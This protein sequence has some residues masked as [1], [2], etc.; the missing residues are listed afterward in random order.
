MKH[1]KECQDEPTQIRGEEKT[2][3]QRCRTLDELALVVLIFESRQ[4]STAC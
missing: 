4:I 2:L 3:A 1:E